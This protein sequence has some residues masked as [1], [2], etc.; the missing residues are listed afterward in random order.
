MAASWPSYCC[1]GR[2][3]SLRYHM[4]LAW[5]DW[6]VFI[7]TCWIS[8]ILSCNSSFKSHR[9]GH[10]RCS[11]KKAFRN[12]HRKAPVLL[13]KKDL[14][15]ALLKRLQHTCLPVNIAKFLRTFIAK[16]TANGC[17]WSQ[18]KS[19]T[20]LK[21]V[22]C[23]TCS[24]ISIKSHRIHLHWSVFFNDVHALKLRNENM[25]TMHVLH[26]LI[27]NKQDGWRGEIKVVPLWKETILSY[28]GFTARELSPI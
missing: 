21:Q 11:T 1:I 2:R 4:E 9:S 20:K 28:Y 12:I 6:S 23:K 26:K 27:L 10:Q 14:L 3:I 19:K 22:L 24:Q 15:K 18:N 17:F 25:K 8:V 13:I 5:L 16:N 7:Y